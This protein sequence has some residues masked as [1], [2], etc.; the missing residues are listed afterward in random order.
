MEEETFELDLEDRKDL[1]YLIGGGKDTAEDQIHEQKV[2][3]GKGGD[4]YEKQ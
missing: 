4:V 3:N 2:R 1:H